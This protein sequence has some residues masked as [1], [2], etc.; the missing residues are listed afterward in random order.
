MVQHDSPVVTPNPE[1]LDEKVRAEYVGNIEPQDVSLKYTDPN[2]FDDSKASESESEQAVPVKPKSI[3]ETREQIPD[4][5][6]HLTTEELEKLA[7]KT[8]LRMDFRIL[9]MLCWIY[10]CNQLDRTNIA[11]ARLGGLE[12]D[13]KLT[14]L[15]YQT[16]VSIL[17]VGYTIFQVP[18]NIVLNRLG[19]PRLFI[20][21]L[22]TL[23]GGISACCAAAHSFASLAVLRVL[24]GVVESGFFVCCL[25]YLSCWYTKKELTFRN[26]IL[27]SGSLLS[28]ALSGLLSSAIIRG[29][30]GV[31]GLQPWRWCFLL[32]GLLTVVTVP[33]SYIVLPDNPSNTRFLSQMEK[34]IVIWKLKMDV[35]E[36]DDD[37]AVLHEHNNYRFALK[38]AVRDPKVWLIAGTVS[39]LVAS[40]GVQNFYPSVVETLNYSRTKTL[41]L[42]APPF[43]I[44]MICT[45][46]WARHSDITQERFFHML[47]PVPVAIM[48]YLVA[49]LSTKT[50][51]RYFA[52][53]LMPASIYSSYIICISWIS[54]IVPRPPLKRAVS[55]AMMNTVANVML[56]W[57]G[58]L[59]P[60]HSAP[61][62]RIA[63]SFNICAECLAV[64]FALTLRLYLIRLNKKIAAGTMD[65]HK[66]MGADGRNINKSFRFMF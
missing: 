13:L 43:F 46:C 50:A 11:S 45:W 59:Y 21:V 49:M 66:E 35:G 56:I 10:I 31:G 9:I 18:S 8:R 6:A 34:D 38:L 48:T 15:Q 62:Y 3:F 57:N 55:L 28:G 7:S 60:K 26:A 63:M 65:W 54:H 23:W 4:S 41:L 42:T 53:C 52:M 1:K 14:S 36:Y 64:I 32:E 37:E 19:K 22:M 24:I 58:F 2:G 12:E 33:F 27:F 40:S 44:A 17:F 30:E 25:Y 61:S 29:M 51:P 39:C 20:S 16:A 47:I 5:L